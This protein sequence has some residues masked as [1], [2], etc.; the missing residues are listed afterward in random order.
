ME[1][2]P[3][4]EFD[5][6]DH[7]SPATLRVTDYLDSEL[8]AEFGFSVNSE[9]PSVFGEYPGGESLHCSWDGEIVSHVALVARHFLHPLYSIRVGLIGSVVTS[10]GFRGRGLGRS[11]ME[12]ALVRLKQ[13]GCAIAI[14]WSDRDQFFT[15]AGFTRAGGE[16]TVLI[17]STPPASPLDDAPPMIAFDKQYHVASV[18]RLYSQKNYRFDRSLEEQRRLVAIPKTKIYLTEVGGKI[19][20]YLALNKGADFPNYIHEWGG[21]VEHVRSMVARLATQIPAHEQLGLIGPQTEELPTPAMA[22]G[23]PATTKGSLAWVRVLDPR[24][25]RAVF[26]RTLEASGTP[27]RWDTFSRQLTIGTRKVRL[28][29]PAD[30]AAGILGDGQGD[31]S[32]VLPFFVWGW[33]S[34]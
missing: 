9:Y 14:L 6:C 13:K 24:A 7:P 19:T 34:I 15:R 28:D 29:S 5:L 20:A 12:Q 30:H 3:R 26:F 22:A 27:F 1:T 21:E 8:R 16:Q 10:E 2:S 18:W 17:P 31:P 32:C 25:L 11:L 4:L 33:D 23:A